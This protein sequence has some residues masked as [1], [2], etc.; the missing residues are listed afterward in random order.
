VPSKTAMKQQNPNRER[1]AIMKIGNDDGIG[2]KNYRTK[3]DIREKI[4]DR[5]KKDT[6]ERR[7]QRREQ[8]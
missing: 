7:V 5:T 1:E 8:S 3:P 6:Q 4:M 2:Q